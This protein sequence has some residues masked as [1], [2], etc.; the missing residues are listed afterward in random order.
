MTTYGFGISFHNSHTV[1]I[2]IFDIVHILLKWFFTPVEGK[3]ILV[4]DFIYVQTCKLQNYLV[5]RVLVILHDMNEHFRFCE[6]LNS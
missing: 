3:Q 5:K 6:E 1:I 4:Y 2:L